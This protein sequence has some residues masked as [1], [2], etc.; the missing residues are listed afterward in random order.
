MLPSLRKFLADITGAVRPER[1]ADNDYRLAAAALLVHAV[2]IDGYKSGDENE[3]LRA[4]IE[5][6]FG[7]Q[8]DQ[9][10]ELIREAIAADHEAVDLY[11]F[12]SLINRACD[13][14]GRRRIIAMLWEVVL[15]DGHVGE[16]E[17]NLL[18]RVAD[19]LN[20]PSRER[21]E[22]RQQVAAARAAAAADIDAPEDR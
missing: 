11:R 4:V 13:E 19:L 17:D 1:F 16:F 8:P 6:Q 10:A 22:I 2:T 18:W 3:K 5:A 7:L 9:A 21:I 20:V 14:A 12:T 15:A